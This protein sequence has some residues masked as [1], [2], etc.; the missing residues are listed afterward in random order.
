MVLPDPMP[1]I[2]ATCLPAGR[3]RE[4]L[5]KRGLDEEGGRLEGDGDEVEGDDGVDSDD[6]SDALSDA[7]S[8]K[9]EGGTAMSGGGGGSSGTNVTRSNTM[10]TPSCFGCLGMVFRVRCFSWCSQFSGNESM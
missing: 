8:F 7:W 10:S 1:P 5:W 3:W 6:V 4:K 9:C 2:T